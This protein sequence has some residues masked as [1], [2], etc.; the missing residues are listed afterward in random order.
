MNGSCVLLDLLV[1]ELTD[2]D[3][4][5]WVKSDGVAFI[6]LELR[7]IC[8]GERGRARENWASCCSLHSI[9]ILGMELSALQPKNKKIFVFIPGLEPGTLSAFI[10]G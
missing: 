8:Q 1:V 9:P 10:E 7:L 6:G 2:T 4:R 3:I 5:G